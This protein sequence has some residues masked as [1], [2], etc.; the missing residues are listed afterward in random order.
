MVQ[1]AVKPG[2]RLEQEWL[3]GREKTLGPEARGRREQHWRSC[4]WWLWVGAGSQCYRDGRNC[5]DEVTPVSVRSEVSC[6]GRRGN[7]YCGGVCKEA[8]RN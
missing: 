5:R 1:R 8:A 6:L 7:G 4:V 3:V 2:G